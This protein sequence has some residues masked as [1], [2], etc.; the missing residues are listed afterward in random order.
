MMENA[1]DKQKK[2]MDDLKIGYSSDVSKDEAKQLIDEKV[3]GRDKS[4]TN[5]TAPKHESSLDDRSKS[6]VAQC[7]TKVWG[8]TRTE[9]EPLENVLRAYNYFYKEL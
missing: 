6:I 4:Q 9:Q 5:F 7:L 3:S 8:A 1:T 2:F